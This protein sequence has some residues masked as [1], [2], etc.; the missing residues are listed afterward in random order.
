MKGGIAPKIPRKSSRS[1]VETGEQTRG[2]SGQEDK[3]I[4]E[5]RNESASQKNLTTQ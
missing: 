3:N 2:K 5:P 4:L 1:Q